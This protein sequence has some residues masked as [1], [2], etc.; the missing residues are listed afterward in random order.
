MAHKTI[1]TIETDTVTLPA[2]WA[3]ALIN[4]DYSGIPECEVDRASA[5]VHRLAYEGWQIADC[6]ED[7]R[8]TWSYRLYDPLADCDGG[9]VLDYTIIRR[10][11]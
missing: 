10:K 8:F 3:S 11:I 9:N 7:S 4:S 1:N 5:A 2:C 6:E